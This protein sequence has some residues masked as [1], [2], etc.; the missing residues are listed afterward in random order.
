[1]M[2]GKPGMRNPSAGRSTCITVSLALKST[3]GS[4]ACNWLSRCAAR[5]RRLRAAQDQAQ[6]VLE[7]ALDGLVERQVERLRRDLARGHAA[8][9]SRLPPGWR[10]AP[11]AATAS[12]RQG[13][14]SPARS[15]PQ[16][17]PENRRELV[18]CVKC[19]RT[20]IVCDSQR[21]ASAGK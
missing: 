10:T 2:V 19:L 21:R 1:M 11:A 4:S 12:A 16:A 3:E 5:R 6:I 17:V 9:K 14:R 8:L 18:G 7:A 20:S 13:L 15:L